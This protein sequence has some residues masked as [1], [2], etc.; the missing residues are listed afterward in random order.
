[1]ADLKKSRLENS[2][3]NFFVDSTCIDCGA[4]FWIAPH[5]FSEIGTMSA[6][7]AT[8][9]TKED[10]IDAFTALFSCPVGSI[11]TLTKDTL[12]AEV[13]HSFPRHLV[14]GV[15]H[16][17]FHSQDSFGASS[18][19]IQRTDGNIL[20]D[21][22]RF[23]PQ[24]AKAI[25]QLGGIRYQYLTH[26]DDL[27]DTD[28]YQEYFKSKRIIHLGDV[29]SKTQNYEIILEG[30]DD[31]SLAP[32]LKIIPVPGHT[33]GHTA[34]LFCNEILF[35]GDHL[36]FDPEQNKLMGFKNACWY[37]W[38]IQ[39]ESFRK[40]LNYQFLHILPGHGNPWRAADLETM[41]GELKRLVQAYK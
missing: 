38:D 14:S 15:F 13:A 9:V 27:A 30:E 29:N 19:L 41:K 40:L 22:P 26:K 7:Y 10:R 4:C 34:L 16:C 31:F 21:S 35:T 28:L 33:K 6:A 8:P 20:I 12:G 23:L 37:D 36:A 1:M 3:Q 5:T 18:F 17:G 39:Q 2:S 25:E 24:L 11:G 32:D